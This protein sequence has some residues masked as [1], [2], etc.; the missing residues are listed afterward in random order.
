MLLQHTY[1]APQAVLIVKCCCFRFLDNSRR[2]E[3]IYWEEGYRD[4]SADQHSWT[5]RQRN[6]KGSRR[7]RRRRAS[8]A[9][10]SADTSRQSSCL[11]A[12]RRRRT[13]VVWYYCRSCKAKYVCLPFSPV[14]YTH[15]EFLPPLS[16]DILEV[17]HK[18]G[19]R[20]VKLVQDFVD[21]RQRSKGRHFYVRVNDRPLFLKGE[22]C[23]SWHCFWPRTLLDNFRIKLDPN[24]DVFVKKQR[25]AYEVFA[26]LCSWSR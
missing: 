7:R 22:S 20:H 12:K 23:C 15:C 16:T 24:L 11:V 8:D 5:R 3:D 13:E 17:T 14:R 1:V 25:R 9:F 21:R 10:Q 26:R 2:S 18:V 6:S 19:F 4:E